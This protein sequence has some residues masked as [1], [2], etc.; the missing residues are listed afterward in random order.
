MGAHENTYQFPVKKQKQ[1][2]QQ[3]CKLR[4][5]SPL[6]FDKKAKFTPKLETL[7]AN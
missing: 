5:F 4:L 3:I 7:D 1:R 2:V 6:K